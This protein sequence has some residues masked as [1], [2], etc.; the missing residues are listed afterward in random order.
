M[1]DLVSLQREIAGDVSKK[2]RLKLTAAEQERVTKTYTTDSE[3]QQYYLKGRFHWNKRKEEDFEKALEYFNKA[4]EEDPNYAVAHAGLADTYALI[5][6][7]GDFRPRDYYPRAKQAAQKA[8]EVDDSLSEAHASLGAI[9]W[10]YE[11]DSKTAER[12]YRKAI[13]LNPKYPTAHQWYAESLSTTEKDKDAANEMSRALQLDPFSRVINRN[14]GHISYQARRYD[15][16]IVQINKD[17]VGGYRAAA[18][19]FRRH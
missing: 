14:I 15:D 3:A 12:E 8:L 5:P 6:Q 16:S 11:Y 9:V 4:I 19:A 13:E 17:R 2:L 18:A 1:T 7:Y 10:S